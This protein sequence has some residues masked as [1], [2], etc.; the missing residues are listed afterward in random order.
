MKVNTIFKIA[1]LLVIVFNSCSKKDTS[2]L[3]CDAGF[4]GANCNLEIRTKFI[5][6]FS[7]V[8][9]FTR[10]LNNTEV[11]FTSN[12]ETSI[13]ANGT[14]VLNIKIINFF[15]LTSLGAGNDNFVVARIENETIVI[16]AQ[17]VFGV[18]FQGTGE[19][20]NGII[21]INWTGEESSTLSYRGTSKYTL[22]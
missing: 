12:Y 13:E 2:E 21:T 8:D 14:G 10:T 15:D 18:T 9:N 17:R 11:D 4:E 20:V 16:D 5:G 22:K 7:V 1:F 3:I 6:D 19:I